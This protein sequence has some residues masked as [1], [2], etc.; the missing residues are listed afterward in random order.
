MEHLSHLDEAV[1]QA[2]NIAEDTNPTVEEALTLAAETFGTKPPTLH[3]PLWLLKIVARI[4]G[5]LSAR[6]GRIPDLE[7]DAV[8]Y[9]YDDY[10]VD[11]AKL[12]ATG[13]RLR[14]PDFRASMAQLKGGGR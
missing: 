12:K 5:A 11:N 14:F 10:I 13:Y 1:G 8:R 6:R 4:D 2:Y 7:Y 9:L 3:L